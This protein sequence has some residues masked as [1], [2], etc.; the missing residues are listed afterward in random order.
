MF[1]VSCGREVVDKCSCLKSNQVHNV[2]VLF[3]FFVIITVP[4]Q[5]MMYFSHG[6]SVFTI[7]YLFYGSMVLSSIL[8]FITLLHFIWK[9]PY[10]PL[11]F[12]CHQRIERT[13]RFFHNPLPLC[14]RCTGIYV[15]VFL[16][17]VITYVN[18]L[19][20]YVYLLVGVPMIV[21]GSLQ[22]YKHI[23]SNN[24]R[25]FSTGLL[26]GITF[27]YIFTMYNVFLVYGIQQLILYIT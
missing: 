1:C 16:A 2:E 10:L 27:S 15:G 11:F 9:R 7:P 4:L 5:S 3:L 26:F 18:V 20:W 24:T 17:I 6:D 13:F 12:G 19:P 21:D 14:A 8:L 22:K 23:I 25:R